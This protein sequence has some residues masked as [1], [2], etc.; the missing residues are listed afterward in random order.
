MNKKKRLLALLLAVS[1]AIPNVSYVSADDATPSDAEAVSE[2]EASEIPDTE[3]VVVDSEGNVVEEGVSEE[4]SGKMEEDPPEV[5]D[6]VTETVKENVTTEETVANEATTEEDVASEEVT[7]EKQPTFTAPVEGVDVSGIDFSSKQLL[8]GTEDENIFTWD[9]I[10]LS[11]Y[12]G[13]YLTEYASEEETKN[14]YTYYYGKADFVDA[15]ITFTVSDDEEIKE[16]EGSS[17]DTADLSEINTGDDAISNL[18]DM[19]TTG[20]VPKGTIA[21]IDTGSNDNTIDAVSLIGDS[22]ADDNGHGTKVINAI[23]SAYPDAKIVS[24]KALGSDG[25]CDVATLYAAISYAIEKKVSIINLSVSSVGTAESDTI[26]EVIDRAV[27]NGIVVVGAAGNNGKNAKYYVP[28]GID[29]AIIVGSYNENGEKNNNSNYGPTVDYYLK[30]NSTSIAAAKMSAVIAKDGIEAIEKNKEDGYIYYPASED[31]LDTEGTVKYSHDN[32]IYFEGAANRNAGVAAPSWY[33]EVKSYITGTLGMTIDIDYGYWSAGSVTYNEVCATLTSK[34]INGSYP[35]KFHVTQT[36]SAPDLYNQLKNSTNWK[37]ITDSDKWYYHSN[38]FDNNWIDKI[39]PGDVIIWA[40]YSP[41]N[42]IYPGTLATSSLSASHT[43]LATL[44]GCVY[45]NG[46]ND[47][48]EPY[49][50][51]RRWVDWETRSLHGVSPTDPSTGKYFKVFRTEDEKDYYVSVKKVDGQGNTMNGVTF[52]LTVNGTTKTKALTTGKYVNGTTVSDTTAGIATYYLGKF[53]SEPTVVVKENWVDQSYVHNTT[54]KTVTACNTKA[55]AENNAASFLYTNWPYAYATMY[56]VSNDTTWTNDNPSYSFTGIK[57]GLYDSNDKLIATVTLTQVDNQ[58]VIKNL[59]DITINDTTTMNGTVPQYYRKTVGGKHCV[60]GLLYNNKYYWKETYVPDGCGYI[61]DTAKHEFTPTSTNVTTPVNTKITETREGGKFRV[62]KLVDGVSGTSPAGA[63]YDVWGTGALSDY[64]GILTI[65][66]D[67]YSPYKENFAYGTYKIKERSVPTTAPTNGEW[68]IDPTTYTITLAHNSGTK[69]VTSSVAVTAS[70]ATVEST[71]IAYKYYYVSVK[72]V[73]DEGNTMNGVTFDLTVNGTTTTKALT[74][75]KY[76]NGGTVSNTSNG[77]ATYY[78]GKFTSEPTVVVKENWTNDGYVHNTTSKTVTAYNTRA[79]AENHATSFLY[80][81][82]KKRF[83]GIYKKDEKNRNISATFDIYGTNSSGTT[84]GGAKIGSITT[85]ASNG[86]ASYEVTSYYNATTSNVNGKYK[87]FYAVE[88]HTDDN[89]VITVTSKALTVHAGALS[90]ADYTTW[91]NPSKVYAYLN[92]QS[93]NPDCTDGNPNY[94][95]TGAEY[96]VFTT[97]AAAQNALNSNNFTGAIADLTV[98]NNT[99]GKTDTINVSDYMN[100][101]STTG[102]FENTNFYIVES[103]AGKNYLRSTSVY[104]LTVTPSNDSSNPAHI[105]VTDEPVNDPF[106]IELIK[107]DLI[108]GS[109]VLPKDKTLEG[110]KFKVDFYAADIETVLANA[111][112]D[113]VGYLKSHY[114]P[115]ADYS[116]EVTITK[117]N[118]GQ[119]YARINNSGDEYPIGFIVITETQPPTDYTDA[120]SKQYIV[121]TVN[122]ETIDVTG[123]LAFVTYRHFTNDDHSAYE[124]KTYYPNNATTLAELTRSTGTKHGVDVSNGAGLTNNYIVD[125]GNKPIRGDVKLTKVTYADGTPLESVEFVIKNLDTGEEHS[126][127]TDAQGNATTVGNEDAWFSKSTDDND[128]I[129]Y[130]AG[131]GALPAGNYT[132]TEKRSEANEKYQLLASEPFTIDSESTILIAASDNK[133]YNIEMPYITTT[134]MDKVTLSKS[135]VQGETA[136]IIDTIKYY[137]LRANSKF[138]IVGTLMVRHQDGTYEPYMKDGEPYTVTSEAINTPATWTKSE[139]EIDGEYVMEFPDVDPAGYEGCSFVVFQKLYYDAVPNKDSN[140]KQYKEYAGTDEKIFPVLHEDIEEEGQTVRSVDIHTTIADSVTDDHI[141][142]TGDVTVTDRVYYTGLTID[143]YYTIKGTLHVTG[144]SWK[145]ADGNLIKTTTVDGEE[146][147]DADGNPITAEQTFQAKSTDGYVDLEFTFDASLLEGESVVAFESLIYKDREIAVHADISDEDETVHFPMIHTTLYREGTGEWAEDYDETDPTK[148]TTFDESS[149]EVMAAEEAVVV[150]RIKYH[151]FIAGRSYVVK[152]ILID[153]ATG[154]PLLDA[155]GNKIEV[156]QKFTLDEVPEES[157][158]DSPDAGDYILADGTV[159]D[160]SADHSVQLVDGFFEVT[161]PAFDASNMGNKTAVAY[162]EVYLLVSDAAG[163]ETEHLLAEHKDKDDVDQTVRFVEIHTNAAVEETSSKLVPIEGEVT[164]NDTVIYKNL[165]PGKEYTLTARPVVKGDKTE[166]YKDGDPL[167]DVKGKEVVATITFI[168]DEPDGEIIV[169]ITFEGYLI[170]ETSIVCYESMTND[171]GLE[172]AI[173]NDIE[174]RSQT[175]YVVDISTTA[176]GNSTGNNEEFA[177]EETVIIDTVNYS[178]LEIGREFKIVG[179]IIDKESGEALLDKDGNPITAETT[180]KAESVDGFID[181]TFPAF[182]ATELAGKDIVVFEKLY[183]IVTTVDAEGKESTEEKI[184]AKHENLDDIGQT[185]TFPEIKTTAKDKATGDNVARVAEEIEV[186]DVVEYKGLKTDGTAYTIKGIMMVVETG[187]PLLDADGRPVTAETTFKAEKP[188]GTVD[189]VFTFDSSLLEGETLCVFEDL[190]RNNKHIATHNDIFS[191][192]QTLRFPKVRTKAE[193]AVTKENIGEAGKET[194]IIDSVFFWNLEIGKSYSIKGV[195][196][197]QATGE[198]LLDANGEKVTAE[199]TFVAETKD[200]TVELTFTFDGSL[201]AGETVIVF[202]NLWHN[203]ILLTGHTDITDENQSEHHPGIKTRATDRNT[204][205]QVGYADKT[206]TIVDEVFCTNLIPN[207]SYEIQGVLYDRDTGKEFL[208]DGKPVMAQKTFTAEKPNCVVELEFTFDGSALK[209][210]A[211]VVFEDLFYKGKKLATH[212]NLSDKDQTVY[213]P[214][215]QT[216]VED[217]TKRVQPVENV[218]VKDDVMF[219]HLKT[220]ERYQLMGVLVDKK[221]G[222]NIMV[223][224][225]PVRS[226]T[227]FTPETE[228]GMITMEFH[229]DATGLDGDVTVFEYLSLVKDIDNKDLNYYLVAE[230]TDLN[231]TEQTFV[232]S[233]VP[234]TGD[235]TPVNI[236][237]GLLL[238]SGLGLAY[239][240]LKKK[241]MIS[242]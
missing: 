32:A 130:T 227:L 52:D 129:P 121:D 134:A 89:H 34:I 165:K 125:V 231:D 94:D 21:V 102:L 218:V 195:L 66:A 24:V 56:K 208:V 22:T 135:L 190:Y 196:M 116:S 100:K 228:D 98:Q 53:S 11:S 112:G 86:K 220:G 238:L 157:I 194:T 152:G 141:A 95:L 132:I 155:E 170:P 13:I 45:N 36:N 60:G 237:F 113:I 169:P 142:K 187:E 63:V 230:H 55:E 50:G 62:H 101:N 2:Q 139:F 68:S 124:E 111:N 6:E 159:L 151:N 39:R 46:E 178:G 164:I 128:P 41:S 217:A 202:E 8:V 234:K 177:T 241:N 176:K 115:V 171:K 168:P 110:A 181:I 16:S 103:K 215:V 120:D 242:R 26:R 147:L 185:V 224:G 57:Y 229:F 180:F 20:T 92:K 226:T 188:D 173:H 216:H 64:H 240:V 118:A 201:L 131:Y 99:N 4:G 1:L 149:K 12:N 91:P 80:T 58:G 70:D 221:T 81:N 93:S 90:N 17:K 59:T 5:T 72:K 49:Y 51:Y 73:D 203:D 85:S 43:E 191:E 154:E 47:E 212:A 236:L 193:D 209:G 61:Q 74:T 104:T 87:Y 119:Y 114:S 122:D 210:T 233:P 204:G 160:M 219:S 42:D 117:N 37:E 30:A 175:T 167:L 136:T 76:V 213:Y 33:N 7:K 27:A 35:S 29:S 84:S 44:S 223:D 40:N 105:S 214:A 192:P 197:N 19:D 232:I 186:V 82:V 77:I 88:T 3:Y 182:D 200:G 48:Y 161:F 172:I 67:G 79:E 15:N 235:D 207:K 211:I 174:D 96:K 9:T 31:R 71:D 109:N 138:F 153:K 106:A 133:L 10:V 145:D 179:S 108:T 38:L 127:F 143:E 69:T 140:A 239:I 162:E 148:V 206:V 225:L 14:A 205:E 198:E 156:E 25:R 146:L 163:D 184:L 54:S 144:Y 83:V 137:H 189:V 150:D 23:Q 97:R 107:T 78:L 166:T 126:I 199:K 75:G 18:V 123:K 65:G 183:I 28:G 158:T 222:K